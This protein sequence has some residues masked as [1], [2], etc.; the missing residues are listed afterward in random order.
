MGLIVGG[1]E[2]LSKGGE[3]VPRGLKG[4]KKSPKSCLCQ[5]HSYIVHVVGLEGI[6]PRLSGPGG[7][8]M[9]GGVCVIRL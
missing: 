7:C 3:G 4:E 2:A 9:W 5:Y 1:L 6:V 8:G